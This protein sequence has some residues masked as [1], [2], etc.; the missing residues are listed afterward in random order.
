[1]AGKSLDFVPEWQQPSFEFILRGVRIKLWI[2]SNPLSH[3]LLRV[4]RIREIPS[5]CLHAG[6]C[7]DRV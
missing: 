2:W 4:N 5:S 1:M 7:N 6:K 3:L